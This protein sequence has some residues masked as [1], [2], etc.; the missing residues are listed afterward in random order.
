M[1]E[2]VVKIAGIAI[3]ARETNVKKTA[4]LSGILIVIAVVVIAMSVVTILKPVAAMLFQF[5]RG[6]IIPE[7]MMVQLI[8]ISTGLMRIDRLVLLGPKI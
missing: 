6:A 2:I 1:T 5:Q 7:L 3:E 4:S 8:G